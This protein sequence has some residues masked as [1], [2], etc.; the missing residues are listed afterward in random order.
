MPFPVEETYVEQAE[1]KLGKRLPGAYRARLMT[2]NGG[3][4]EAPPCGWYL[5][6]VLDTSSR[7]RLKRT[8]NDIVLETEN[9]KKWLGFPQEAVAIGD[10]GGGDK[11]IFMP[12]PEDPATVQ[13]VLF[14]WDHETGQIR[15]IAGELERLFSLQPQ[16]AG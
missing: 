15:E 10:N 1:S 9:S 11:L 13:P 16:T 5:Y 12:R 2:E 14:W 7:K 3:Y 6:P 4:L 8:C